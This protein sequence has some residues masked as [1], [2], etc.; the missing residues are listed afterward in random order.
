[1]KPLD[2]YSY[3]RLS[4]ADIKVLAQIAKTKFYM[5]NNSTV[6]YASFKDFHKS[7]WMDNCNPYMIKLLNKL[8]SKDYVREDVFRKLENLLHKMHSPSKI[9][10]LLRFVYLYFK[11]INEIDDRSFEDSSLYNL[12]WIDYDIR[13]IPLSTVVTYQHHISYMNSKYPQLCG[14]F[15]E[16]CCGHVMNAYYKYEDDV[17]MNN[18][19]IKEFF[20]EKLLKANVG[21]FR[22][23]DCRIWK[24]DLFGML[25]GR[26][27]IHYFSFPNTENAGIMEDCIWF[28][29]YYEQ[30]F[31]KDFNRF[32]I[33][34]RNDLESIYN[35]TEHFT[36][37]IS[38][39]L[40]GF[41]FSKSLTLELKGTMDI[42]SSINL[43]DC[44]VCRNVNEDMKRKWFYQLLLYKIL[45]EKLTSS[46]LIDK[47]N[48]PDTCLTIIDGYNFN[49]IVYE[50]FREPN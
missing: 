29:E 28:L 37:N 7:V 18:P 17:I 8:E 12:V 34:L 27:I 3:D 24:H 50:N 36:G 45:K 44:K 23:T 41:S 49:V 13:T 26:A 33:M 1:M 19:G 47:L 40:S 9:C 20:K 25:L 38:S 22:L 5:K 35:F 32:M 6:E 14:S 46:N 11:T 4:E 48:S 43:I 31:K 42:C 39:T 16:A 10:E 30:S 2:R 15:F 21:M